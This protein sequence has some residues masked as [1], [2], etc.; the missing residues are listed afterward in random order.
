MH[1][2]A[3]KND[4]PNKD[5]PNK[6][7]M[8]K[9]LTRRDL[10]KREL[11]KRE[12]LKNLDLKVVAI[13]G[14][15]YTSRS[16]SATAA[17]LSVRQSTVSMALAR[18]RKHFDDPLFVR[19][20]AGM[21]PTPRGAELIEVLKNAEFYLRKA[22]E[23]RVAFEPATSDRVFRLC[24]TDIA[25]LTLLPTLLKRLKRISPLVSVTLCNISGPYPGA[26]GIGRR[27]SR[28]RL[29]STAE[30]GLLWAAPVSG[31]LCLR[32]ADRSSSSRK[33]PDH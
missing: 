30:H 29:H 25:Q 13:I 23:H 17:N 12:V 28:G 4:V 16:V 21:E 22:L 5:A 9:D 14:D 6:A 19:T 2:D 7:L 27:G 31:S 1:H 18:L 32:F 3:L 33:K 11:I 15:L 20:S 24:S 10:V 26:A 8:H